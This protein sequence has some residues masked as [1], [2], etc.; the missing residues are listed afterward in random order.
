M[1]RF[2]MTWY[3]ALAIAMAAA[4]MIAYRVRGL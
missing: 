2:E 4:L 3:M 1:G